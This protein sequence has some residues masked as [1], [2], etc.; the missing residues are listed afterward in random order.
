MAVVEVG[1]DGLLAA[2]A[3]AEVQS[4]RD[5]DAKLNVDPFGGSNVQLS[6]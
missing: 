6:I 1:A 2:A 4:A 5:L 3:A